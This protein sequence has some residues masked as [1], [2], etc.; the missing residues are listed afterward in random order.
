MSLITVLWS[1]GA[2]TALTV[3]VIY[4]ATRV[5]EGRL[6]PHLLFGRCH[7]DRDGRAVRGQGVPGPCGAKAGIGV[8][9]RKRVTSS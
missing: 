8:G 9:G 5:F 7:R 3:A 1:M 4:G 6:V 2:A